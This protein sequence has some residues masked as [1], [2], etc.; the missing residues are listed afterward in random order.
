[1]LHQPFDPS[2]LGRRERRER[3]PGAEERRQ[4]RG[5]YRLASATLACPRCALPIWPGSASA[6]GAPVGCPYCRH[7]AP[8]RDFLR[9]GETGPGE[10]EV[11][12]RLPGASG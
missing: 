10:V 6:L 11:V 3:L 12:A 4:P 9:L 5:A 2:D 8:T 1:M 7:T